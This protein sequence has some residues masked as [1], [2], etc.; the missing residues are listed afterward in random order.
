MGKKQRVSGK[1]MATTITTGKVEETPKLIEV[2]ASTTE[3]AVSQQLSEDGGSE[4][5]ASDGT[6]E[7]KIEVHATA[8]HHEKLDPIVAHAQAHDLSHESAPFVSRRLDN[9]KESSSIYVTLGF[10][11]L[12]LVAAMLVGVI[13]LKR[14]QGKH[15]HLQ[16]FVEV[17]QTASPE[18]R[19]VAAMQMNGYETPAYKCFEAAPTS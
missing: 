14:R 2:E 11:G 8:V 18:E 17:D 7:L 3:S 19:H 12:A 16:G 1:K 6:K 10:A 15:P 5:A 13:V 9:H 4:V